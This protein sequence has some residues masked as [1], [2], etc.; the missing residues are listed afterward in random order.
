[1]PRRS[2]LGHKSALLLGLGALI[3][4]RPAGWRAPVVLAV[5]ALVVILATILGV[6]AV[7][8]YSVPVVP[9]FILFAAVGLFGVRRGDRARGA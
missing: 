8:E 1:M 4:R 6:Y 3:F 2:T 9:S 5:A 7:P